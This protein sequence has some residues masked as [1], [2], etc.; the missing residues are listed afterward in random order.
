MWESYYGPR[1]SKRDALSN[2]EFEK[3]LKGARELKEYQSL[4]AR[5]VI[6]MAGRLGMRKGEITHMTQDWVDWKRNMI[7]I[8]YHEPCIKARHFS[9]FLRPRIG[10]NRSSMHHKTSHEHDSRP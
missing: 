9:D 3:L 10:R 1:H 7:C 5:F 8:P 2:R 6:F 4:Q